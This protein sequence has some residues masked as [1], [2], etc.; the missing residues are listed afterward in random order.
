MNAYAN[1]NGVKLLAFVAVFAMVVCAFAV[2]PSEDADAA[3]VT[4]GNTTYISGQIIATQNYGDNTNVVINGDLS[5]PAGMSL[6]ISGTAKF[7]VNE[8]ATVTIDAGGQLIFQQ[9]DEKVPTIAINGSIVADGIPTDKTNYL[10]AII[11]NTNID[12]DAGLTVVGTITLND[13][14]YMSTATG[15]TLENVVITAPSSGKGDVVLKSGATLDVNKRS[16]NVSYVASQNINMYAGSTFDTEG[17]SYGLVINAVGDS[18]Y[19]TGEAFRFLPN[20]RA[21]TTGTHPISRLP[22]HPRQPLHTLEM[23]PMQG[24]S[25]SSSIS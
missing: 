16:S 8:G 25:R 12:D 18:V 20:G 4:D 5:I 13:G 1:K 17:Y 10:C 7:T 6:I 14:A 11:N 24:E 2:M 15:T 19:Y 22:S 21:I 9:V 3:V 23:V